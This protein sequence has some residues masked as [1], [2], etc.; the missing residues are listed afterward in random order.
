LLV[1][2][3]KHS[4]WHATNS[5]AA[6]TEQRSLFLIA[7]KNSGAVM[8][9]RNL[10]ITAAVVAAMVTPHIV[11]A[12]P[13]NFHA[14]FNAMFAKEKT[15]KLSLK[16]GSTSSVE[17]K[18]GEQVMTLTAGQAINLNL[19]V[20][21]RIVANTDTTTVKAGTLIAEVSK[22]LSGSVVTLK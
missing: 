15:V 3:I 11:Y 8:K 4:E 16:N 20:G 9:S 7:I 14:P 21:T 22:E 17:V 1:A 19:P 13:V 10:V 2:D 5:S 6:L 12:T 18:V